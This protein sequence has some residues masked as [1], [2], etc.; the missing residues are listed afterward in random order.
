[1]LPNKV[2]ANGILPKLYNNT[3]GNEWSVENLKPYINKYLGGSFRLFSYYVFENS[4]YTDAEETKL[5]VNAAM[6][7]GS[8]IEQ[9]NSIFI[10]ME[11]FVGQ[12]KD[13]ARYY[14]RVQGPQYANMTILSKINLQKIFSHMYSKAN[15]SLA[16]SILVGLTGILMMFAK[17]FLTKSVLMKWLIIRYPCMDIALMS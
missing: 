1:M 5:Y 15:L 12:Y 17:V 9:H 13:K 14:S 4:Y 2:Q 7:K 6:P 3:L 8:T 16:V 10:E 11:D